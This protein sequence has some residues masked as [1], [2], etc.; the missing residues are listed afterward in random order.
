MRGDTRL[1]QLLAQHLHQLEPHRQGLAQHQLPLFRV[2]PPFPR[3]HEEPDRLT[4]NTEVI[5]Y[6]TQLSLGMTYFF[7]RREGLTIV[8]PV[9]LFRAA[10][11]MST[12]VPSAIPAGPRAGDIPHQLRPLALGTGQ[13]H[14]RE[15]AGERGHQTAHRQLQRPRLLLQ[16]GSR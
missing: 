1:H 12:A 13:R 14:E 6:T 3:H 4:A 8:L 2:V 10:A 5:N 9:Q 15:P 7:N 16:R 11:F